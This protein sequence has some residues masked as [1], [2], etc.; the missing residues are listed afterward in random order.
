MDKTHIGVNHDLDKVHTL[1]QVHQLALK[2]MNIYDLAIRVA[3]KYLPES[4]DDLARF[5]SDSAPSSFP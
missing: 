3:F 5:L 2:H 4:P 1:D